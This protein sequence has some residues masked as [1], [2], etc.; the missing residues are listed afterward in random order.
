MKVNFNLMKT[1]KTPNFT[2]FNH[3]KSET[4]SNEF[5]FNFPHD[6]NKYDCYLEVF[7]VKKDKNDNYN[8]NKMLTNTDLGVKSVKLNNRGVKLTWVMLTMN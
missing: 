2:G 3:K 8:V 6:S 5:E 7:S 4:G 1:V